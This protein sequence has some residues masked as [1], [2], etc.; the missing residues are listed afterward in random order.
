VNLGLKPQATDYR[1]FR[2]G[3]LVHHLRLHHDLWS[4]LF[5]RQHTLKPDEPPFSI[6]L[7]PA[8]SSP[9]PKAFTVKREVAA[10]A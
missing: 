1:S 10:E 6:G 8:T 2:A 5:K 3:I 9:I 7:D 4:L